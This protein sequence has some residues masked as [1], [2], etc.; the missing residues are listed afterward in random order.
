MGIDAKSWEGAWRAMKEFAEAVKAELEKRIDAEVLVNE[1]EK[2]RFSQNRP[3]NQKSRLPNRANVLCG[4]D[5]RQ[6]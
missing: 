5:G 1:I 4:T 2:Q 6:F 3:D